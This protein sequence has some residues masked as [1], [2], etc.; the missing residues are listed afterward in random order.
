MASAAKAELAGLIITTQ[1][2]VP[3][4]NNKYMSY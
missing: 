1:E 3:L 2:M 4:R